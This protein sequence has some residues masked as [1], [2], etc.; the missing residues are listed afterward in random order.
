MLTFKQF[1]LEGGHA[2]SALNTSRATKDDIAR[3]LDFVSR[4]TGIDKR[5]LTDNLLGSTSHTLAGKKKDSGDIDIALEDGMFDRAAVVEK[6][7]RATGMDKVHMTGGNVFSF[8]VPT[9]GDRKVQVDLMFVP[10][11]RWARFGYYS[12]I[13]SKHKGAVRNLLLVNV[14]KRIFEKGKDI[15]VYDDAHD[16]EAVRVRR[17]FKMDAGL[18]RLFRVAPM[19]KDGKGR[20]ALRKATPQ[21]VEITLKQLGRNDA[22]SRDEDPITDPDKAAEFM[23]GHG[24]KGKDILS[25]EQVIKLIFKRPDHAEIF[26]D[27]IKDIEAIDQP[28]PDEIKQFA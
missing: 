8:A 18:E 27:A 26:K 17:G 3:A 28:V 6:M 13:N 25:A 4:V 12:D 15:S 21:E 23:F 19:R 24:V 20:T 9:T 16:V 5:K 10:S 2:T 7:R 1:L 14:M 22:F 11:E